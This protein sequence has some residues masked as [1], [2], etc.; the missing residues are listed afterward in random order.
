MYKVLLK[1]RL[2]FEVTR[3]WNWRQVV[4]KESVPW[5][6][7]AMYMLDESQ[8]DCSRTKSAFQGTTRQRKLTQ[9]LMRAFVHEN[10]QYRLAM[11]LLGKITANFECVDKTS[12]VLACIRYRFAE[13]LNS[14]KQGITKSQSNKPDGDWVVPVKLSAAF[15]G[16]ADSESS[17]TVLSYTAQQPEIREICLSSSSVHTAKSLKTSAI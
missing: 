11:G 8:L 4:E 17:L 14:R 12:R 13:T 5:I 6:Q 3:H 9:I 16:I 2:T 7:T 1:F 15:G 10:S